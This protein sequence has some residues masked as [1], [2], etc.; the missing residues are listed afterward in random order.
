MSNNLTDDKH[1]FS[2]GIYLNIGFA[3]VLIIAAIYLNNE[4]RINARFQA[5]IEA[6][7]RAQLILDRNLATHTYFSQSLKPKVLELT[8]YEKNENYFEPTW[9]SSTFAVK[10]IDENFRSLNDKKYYYKEC[11]VNA[12]TPENEADEFEK[13]FIEK[14]NKNSELKYVSLVRKLK[15]KYY[16]VTLRR[17]EVMEEACLQCH[18]T[19]DKA[20]K[21]LVELYGSKRGYNR[22]LNE[23]VSAISIRVPLSAAYENADKFSKHISITFIV[24]LL[25]IFTIQFFVHRF[26][27]IKPISKLKNKARD[28]SK[29]EKLLGE[30]ISLPISREFGELATVFNKLSGQLRYQMDNLEEMVESRTSELKSSNEKLRKTLDENKTLKG[31][32]PICMHCKEI[33][34]DKG[35]WNKLEKYLSKYSDAKFTHSICDKCIEKHYPDLE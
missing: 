22:F 34:D 5:L 29:N 32:I 30:T 2:L 12:R 28:I 7:S 26:L 13:E 24:V 16:Y 21:R 14:L 25:I 23:V 17:G 15:N 27:I 9:M 19:P 6:E 10:K 31:I 1:R 18:S 4:I 20:P 3:I 8:R 33:R 11:A 35:Y